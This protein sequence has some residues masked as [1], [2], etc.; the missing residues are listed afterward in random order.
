M[1]RKKKTLRIKLF[2]SV[3]LKRRGNRY[4]DIFN[5][6]VDLGR[7]IITKCQCKLNIYA[8]LASAEIFG[9][10]LREHLNKMLVKTLWN[11]TNE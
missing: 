7:I 10:E 9:A 5:R 6:A 2:S 3:R 11:N 1:N 8:N 4:I